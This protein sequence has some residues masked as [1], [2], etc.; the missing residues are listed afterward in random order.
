MDHEPIAGVEA[1]QRELKEAP[2][3]VEAK[4]ELFG[5]GVFVGFANEHRREAAYKM[6][7]SA[8]PCLRAEG[9]T[10]MRHRR[11]S[12]LESHRSGRRFPSGPVSQGLREGGRLA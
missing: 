3:G 11:G 5:G 10:F 2:V 1:Q 6:S 8:N 9:L 4:S 7:S 12:Q